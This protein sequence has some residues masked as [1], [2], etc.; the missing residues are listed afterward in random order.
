[1]PLR[2]AIGSDHGGFEFKQRLAR[3]LAA[4]GHVVVDCGTY[5]AESCDYPVFAWRVAEWVAGGGADRGVLLCR[6]GNGVA[7][8]ANKHPGV[9]A[10]FAVSPKTAE[11]ARTHNEANVLVVGCDHIS[12]DLGDLVDA[13]LAAEPEGGRH[14]RRVRQILALDR[15]LAS[16][17]PTDKML[18]AGQST[19]LLESLGNLPPEHTLESLVLFGGVRGMLSR[20]SQ[21]AAALH[22]HRPRYEELL[23]SATDGSPFDAWRR[24]RIRDAADAAD[25][26]RPVY[27]NS[28]GDDGYVVVELDGRLNHDEAG[29]VER[30]RSLVAEIDRPNLLLALPGTPEGLRALRTLTARGFSTI[31][32]HLFTPAQT[33]AAAQ[34]YIAGLRSS[35]EAGLSLHDVR[36]FAAVAVR[37]LAD[38]CGRALAD[39]IEHEPR[40]EERLGLETAG[41]PAALAV[42]R[43]LYREFRQTFFAPAFHDLMG[44]GA[45]PQRLLWLDAVETAEPVRPP[46]PIEEL[47]APF[48]VACLGLD[49]LLGILGRPRVE[50]ES[51]LDRNEV[52]DRE[53]LAEICGEGVELER[54]GTL[55]QQR[56]MARW[57]DEQRALLDLLAAR[58]A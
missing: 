48:T 4:R 43:Q 8:V 14:H 37:D 20:G 10:G 26:L 58:R 16:A 22:A 53:A 9:R 51:M 2:I 21:L 34:A 1:M 55:L 32:L 5:T 6:S 41:Y 35:R 52:A 23:A 15:L 42:A 7:M 50:G 13:W 25:V 24:L 49:S 46:F 17:R 38:A 36:S 33:R 12:H 44:E 31:V 28:A 11:L 19:W 3:H 30:V 27:D 56:A 45:A 57:Q 39:G 29:L 54:L 47:L 18:L 40:P